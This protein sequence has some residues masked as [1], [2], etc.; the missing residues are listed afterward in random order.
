MFEVWVARVCV[1]GGGGWEGGLGGERGGG[2]GGVQAMHPA[3][4]CVGGQ[5]DSPDARGE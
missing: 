3:C 4:R 5:S 1:W 2:V